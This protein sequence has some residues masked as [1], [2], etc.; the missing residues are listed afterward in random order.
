VKRIKLTGV[1]L[2]TRVIVVPNFGGAAVFGPVGALERATLTDGKMK[3]EIAAKDKGMR[4]GLEA[5]SWKLPMGPALEFDDLA[6]EAVVEHQQATISGIE[7]RI[8]G[9]TIKG[10]ARTSWSP[11]GI[12]VEGDFNV[13]NGDLNR[14]L[15]A[16]T[17]DFTATGQLTTS[18][19]YSLQGPSLKELFSN[20][21]AEATFNLEKGTLSNVDVVR[22]IQSPSREGVRGGRT[23]FNSLTG[24]MQLAGKT[25]SFR[26]LQLASGPMQASGNVEVSANGDLSGRISAELG[27]RTMIVARGTLNVIGNLK[28]PVLKP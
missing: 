12:K 19:T 26:Q 13:T 24:S 22:A 28:T 4:I 17:S 27:S 11:G 3:V 10:G 7:G 20:S 14:L 16:F 1:R 8:A 15:A 18:G 6:L 25:H 23:S 9:T 5:R 21:R 2:T